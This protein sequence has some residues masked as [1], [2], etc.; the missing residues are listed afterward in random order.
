[1]R[2]DREMG[3]RREKGGTGP[4]RSGAP[5]RHNGSHGAV[6]ATSDLQRTLPGTAVRHGK[7]TDGTGVTPMDSPE[8]SRP[9]QG[10]T[11]AQTACST[12]GRARRRS[13][14]AGAA[15]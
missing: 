13:N 11:I 12:S 5:G 2:K 7:D 15:R 9:G 8:D 10:R 14:V 1:M 6:S 3:R 4:L